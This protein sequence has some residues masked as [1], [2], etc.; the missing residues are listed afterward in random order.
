MPPWGKK[1]EGRITAYVNARL[2]LATLRAQLKAY[3]ELAGRKVFLDDLNDAIVR[4]EQALMV[5]TGGQ[6]AVA[7]QRIAEKSKDGPRG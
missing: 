3:P 6:M 1:I 5:L 2:E 4:A 7:V